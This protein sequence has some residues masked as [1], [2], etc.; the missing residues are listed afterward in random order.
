M[1]AQWYLYQI[2][3]TSG[4]IFDLFRDI[5]FDSKGEKFAY[6]NWA[7]NQP[8]NES[9]NENCVEYMNPKKKW[10]DRDCNH[11]QWFVCEERCS[12]QTTP[13]KECLKKN[14]TFI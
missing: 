9:K 3:N 1:D 7:P 14:G 12:R 13:D 4:K 11:H 8:D 10:N 2:Q 6:T 5:F